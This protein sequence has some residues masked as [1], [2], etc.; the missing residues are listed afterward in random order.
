MGIL[1]EIGKKIAKSSQETVKKAKSIAETTRLNNQIAEE[2]RT[3]TAFYAQIGEKYYVSNKNAPAEEYAQF[4]DRVTAGLARIAELQT[5]IQK[6][7]NTR[8]CP[9]CGAACPINVQFCASCGTQLPPMDITEQSPPE[10]DQNPAEQTGE[11]Q[12]DNAENN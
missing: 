1:D 7:K 10:A 5:E 3:L 12:G 2:Q 4:C 6:L 8:F 9:N 11:P